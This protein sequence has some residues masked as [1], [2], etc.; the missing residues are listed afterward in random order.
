MAQPEEAPPLGVDELRALAAGGDPPVRAWPPRRP[1]AR[2]PPGPAGRPRAA[3]C[4]R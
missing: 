2:L 4:S 1:A 3:C